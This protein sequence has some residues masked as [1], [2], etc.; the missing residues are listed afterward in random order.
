MLVVLNFSSAGV[1]WQIPSGLG[2]IR[3]IVI[4]NYDKAPKLAAGTIRMNGWQGVVY[5]LAE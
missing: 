4:N 2:E 5:T 1:D 3:D